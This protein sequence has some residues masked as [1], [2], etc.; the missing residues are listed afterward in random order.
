M[1]PRVGAL[2]G[3]LAFEAK[4]E[5]YIH[6]TVSPGHVAEYRFLDVF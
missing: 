6:W 5:E 3:T 4:R 1:M 2:P